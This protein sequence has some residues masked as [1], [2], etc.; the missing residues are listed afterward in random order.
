MSRI[1]LTIDQ[2]V[3]SGFAP[4]DRIALLEALQTELRQVLADPA[5]RAAWAQTH[6]T[7]VLKLGRMP[8]SLGPS[9]GRSFGTRVAKAIGKG[10]KP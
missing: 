5:T 6:R 3:L 7:P 1:N 2:I 4:A 8:F 9:G 10:L